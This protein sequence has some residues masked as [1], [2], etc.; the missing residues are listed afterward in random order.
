MYHRT[1]ELLISP[2]GCEPISLREAQ[3]QLRQ[4]D[5]S[6]A[7]YVQSLITVARKTLEQW[8]WSAFIQQTWQ[9]WWDRFWWKMFVPRGPMRVGWNPAVSPADPMRPQQGTNCGGVVWMGYLQP[10]ALSAGPG[11][12]A[13]LPTSIYETSME[14]EL[15]FIRAAYLQTYPVTRGYRDDVTAKV[16]VGYGPK[17]QDVP[18]PIRQAIKLLVS[19]LYANRGEVPAELPQAIGHL[20]EPYRL[21][22]F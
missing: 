5:Q 9:Y 21:R 20:I 13:T 1:N 18:Q 10:Q 7:D 22:E 11:S 17:P 14:N 3:V 15:P 19:H 16:V 4:D 8:C 2:P 12:Y 6:D